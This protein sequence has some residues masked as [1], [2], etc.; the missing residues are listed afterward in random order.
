MKHVVGAREAEAA[1][2]AGYRIAVTTQP[3]VLTSNSLAQPT[4]LPRVSLNGYFQKPRFVSALISGLPFA[5]I[6]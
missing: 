6:R 5:L 4:E 2:T 1:R 3:G